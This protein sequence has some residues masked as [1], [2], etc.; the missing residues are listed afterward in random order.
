MTTDIKDISAIALLTQVV[1]HKAAFGGRTADDLIGEELEDWLVIFRS[2]ANL[3]AALGA[4]RFAVDGAAA[5]LVCDEFLSALLE[6]GE[7][8]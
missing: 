1:E 5:K 3:A 2:T 4:V 7:V 6:Q 8:T